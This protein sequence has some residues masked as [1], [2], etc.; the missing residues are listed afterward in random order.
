[1]DRDST[2]AIGGFGKIEMKMGT[3]KIA[4]MNRKTKL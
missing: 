4:C 3:Q 1:V 2:I